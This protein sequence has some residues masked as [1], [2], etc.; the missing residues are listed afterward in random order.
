MHSLDWPCLKVSSASAASVAHLTTHA[1][2]EDI[3]RPKFHQSNL[4]FAPIFKYARGN[5]N[6][7]PTKKAESEVGKGQFL[8]A[9]F[10]N[11]HLI[12][13]ILWLESLHTITLLFFL[14]T[15]INVSPF[16]LISEVNAFPTH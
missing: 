6:K 3:S 12:Y 13:R 8:S 7:T 4:A 10:K 9:I 1:L 11:F 14:F 15:F 16:Q 2:Q 5:N